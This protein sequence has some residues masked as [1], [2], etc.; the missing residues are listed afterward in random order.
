MQAS[1]RSCTV[2]SCSWM[3]KPP[4]VWASVDKPRVQSPHAPEE[5]LGAWEACVSSGCS[6][7]SRSMAPSAVFAA[8]THRGHAG[9]ARGF[10]WPWYSDGL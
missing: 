10:L 6:D 2:L 7:P 1:I 9:A 8:C 5:P 4:K 3:L